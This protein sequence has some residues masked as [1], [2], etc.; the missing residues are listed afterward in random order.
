MVIFLP[1]SFEEHSRFFNRGVLISVG[2]LRY[3][4]GTISINLYGDQGELTHISLSK[5]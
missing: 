5:E 3:V 1:K 2:E 4:Q